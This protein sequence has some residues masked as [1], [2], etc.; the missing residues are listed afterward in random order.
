MKYDFAV[1][2]AGPAERRCQESRWCVLRPYLVEKKAWRR[3]PKRR[4]CA[5]QDFAPSS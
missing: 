1:I 2:G 4:L 3:M 5:L